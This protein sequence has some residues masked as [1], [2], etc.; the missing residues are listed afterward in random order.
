MSTENL[1]YYCIVQL[2]TG[3]K[4]NVLLL[5]IIG[6]HDFSDFMDVFKGACFT[7]LLF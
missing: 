7:G 5:N 6:I 4:S 2:R 3:K 1:E